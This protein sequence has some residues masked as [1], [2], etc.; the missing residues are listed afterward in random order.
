[1]TASAVGHGQGDLQ[2]AVPRPRAA[3]RATGARS[4]ASAGRPTATASWPSST[5]SPRAPAIR[6]S[7]SSRP[8]SARSVGMTLAHDAG[9]AGAG[10]RDR[11]RPRQRSSSSRPTW[12]ARATSRSSVIGNDPARLELYGP[13]E[14]VAGHEF[15]D[16][17]AKYTPGLSRDVAGGRGRPGHPGDHP[18]DRPRLLPGDRRRGVRPGRLPARPATG[19]TCPRSTRS[20]ASPRSA[21]SRRWPPTGGY[22]FAAV[23]ERIVELALERQAGRSGAASARRTCPDDSPAAR[24]AGSTATAGRRRQAAAVRTDPARVG[25][26]EP[27]PGRGRPRHHRLRSSRSTDSPRARSFAY[28]RLALTGATYTSEADVRPSSIAAQTGQNLF[29]LSTAGMA[30]RLRSL[31]DRPR[32][33]GRGV[34]AGHP[35]GPARRAGPDRDLGGRRQRGSSSTRTAGPSPGTTRTEGPAGRRRP[36]EPPA[37]DLFIG[38][39]GRRRRLRRRDPA[40]LAPARPTSAAGPPPSTSDDRRRP[41]GSPWTAAATAG[42]ATFGFYTPTIRRTDLIPGQVRLLRSLL[43]RP[44]GRRSRRSSWPTSRTGRTP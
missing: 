13:G 25:L 16:Y 32:R 3:R 6:A 8:A 30:E 27:D 22:D 33:I 35:P 12:P 18:E 11:L 23:A 14:I 31:T 29:T 26:V 9:R 2:A 19:S 38:Q 15:Y 34:A 17:A 5:P 43:A 7:W 1:M 4:A 40:R 36:T 28:R 20:R 41:A 44:R 21:S 24:A 10:D 42:V 37:T 39:P